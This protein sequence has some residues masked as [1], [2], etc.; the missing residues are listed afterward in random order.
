MLFRSYAPSKD[1]QDKI[2]DVINLYKDKKIRNFKTAD[3]VIRDLTHARLI[4][5]GKANSNYE[6]I[7]SKYKN[8]EPMTGRLERQ[9]IANQAKKVEEA[10]KTNQQKQ[11]QRATV[12][13]L[14][15][16]AK[17]A[18][19]A[20]RRGQNYSITV[21]KYRAPDEENDDQTLRIHAP[22]ATR[23]ERSE[24]I[25]TAKIGRAHV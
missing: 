14:M 21:R 22:T 24:L 5:S 1:Y 17:V 25:R 2:K 11:E 15:K 6:S 12:A 7:V 19:N 9:A 10:I 18:K 13:K 8:V 20:L 23:D 4:K 16:L 3:N